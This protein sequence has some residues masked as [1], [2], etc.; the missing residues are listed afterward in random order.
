MKTILVIPA[1]YNSTRLPGKPLLSIAGKPMIQRVHECAQQAGFDNIIIATDDERIAEVCA[2]FS[3]DVCMTNEA[4]ETGSD[5]LSEVVALR[6]F[7]D[8]DILVN[9]QGDEP[10]TPSVNLHQVAQNLVDH[11]EAMIAT[12]CTPIVDVEDFTNP[13]VVKVV[14]DN[15]GMAMYFSR[16]S[17]PYQRDPSLD[18][19]DFAFRHIGI[20]AY[21]AKYLRDFVKMESC[22]LEQLEKL[23][24]LRAMWYGTR[25]HV[26]VAKEIPGAGVD[27]AEDLAAVE[28][29][30]LKRLAS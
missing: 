27:T 17:I 14:T 24:Q 15:A 4:H 2:S 18:V 16:A 21:R 6:G 22:Q 9:L 30:F 5:R 13:N 8:D 10:L 11:P 12:L 25:I 7:D 26:D 20:Y 23:E 29:V 1:R 19:T 3:A 28:N